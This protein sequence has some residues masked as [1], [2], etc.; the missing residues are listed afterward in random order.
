MVFSYSWEMDHKSS[1]ILASV[2]QSWRA[3]AIEMPKI[4]SY[5]P[6]DGS[7][8][9]EHV[10]LHTARSGNLP[11]HT[12]IT[13]QTDN[14]TEKAFIQ[15]AHRVECLYLEGAPNLIENT[16]PL[17]EKLTLVLSTDFDRYFFHTSPNPLEVSSFPRLQ[18]LTV[19]AFTSSQLKALSVGL[20]F[21]PLKALSI[22]WRG[23][24]AIKIIQHCSETLVSLEL[25]FST[26]EYHL[27]PLFLPRLKRLSA[28]TMITGSFRTVQEINAPQLRE[29]TL[30]NVLPAGSR[31]ALP[32]VRLFPHPPSVA[33]LYVSGATF[34]LAL[35]PCLRKLWV[36]GVPSHLQPRV[37]SLKEGIL[38]CTELESIH[39]ACYA[40]DARETT[41]LERMLLE[42]IQASP[43]NVA[44]EVIDPQDR[45]IF[46]HGYSTVRY[47]IHVIRLV[48]M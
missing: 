12:R 26:G 8:P 20:G 34:D 6:F 5:I 48:L 11:L 19:I 25:L 33:D 10:Q 41:R 30:Y 42:V 37:S 28:I 4:W 13:G 9:V 24:N 14:A 46:G 39:F 18:E 35:F 44:L 40:G 17:V 1:T 43:R 22:S 45:R 3:S 29:L 2:C 38:S 15:V 47:S 27:S 23:E 32:R 31:A 16:Y 7:F 36:R 21:P